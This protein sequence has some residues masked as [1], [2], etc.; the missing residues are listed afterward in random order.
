MST[1][2]ACADAIYAPTSQSDKRCLRSETIRIANISQPYWNPNSERFETLQQSMQQGR[3]ER[4]LA[5]SDFFAR[6]FGKSR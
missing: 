4:A 5:I 1:Y 6:L 2:S 3:R